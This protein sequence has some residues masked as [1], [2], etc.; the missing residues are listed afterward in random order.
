[1]DKS[2]ISDELSEIIAGRQVQ[3]AVFTSYN[4][5]PDFFEIDVIPYLLKDTIP[6]S[7]DDR[8]K[9]YQVME[10]L[11]DSDIC[12]EVFFDQRMFESSDQSPSMDYRFN[13][14]NLLPYAFHAKNI[15][16]LVKASDT[17]VQ[18]LLMAAGSNNLTRAGWW[19][20]IETQHWV[21]IDNDTAN[22][23]LIGQ[24]R[25]DLEWLKDERN[26]TT[27]DS[28]IEK[29][30]SFLQACQSKEQA[31]P[32][33]YYS[34]R[35]R[36]FF[37]FIE[38]TMSSYSNAG[39][40]RLEIISPF[41]ANDPESLLHE[42]FFTMGVR[43]ILILLPFDQDNRAR[44][45][46]EY[47]ETIRKAD[48]IAWAQWSNNDAKNLGVDKQQE[49]YRKLHAKVF[50]F[51]ND[52][53]S[54]VFSGSVNF[55]RNA[56]YRNVESGFLIR[57][58]RMQPLLQAISDQF[59]VQCADELD[60][61]ELQKVSDHHTHLDIHL[62]YDWKIQKLRGRV[63]HDSLIRVD[64]LDEEG[65]PIIEEWTLGQDEKEYE[66][67]GDTT[68][69]EELLKR[70]SFV[71]VLTRQPGSDIPLAEQTVLVLQTGWSHKPVDL[72]D[73]TPEE[74]LL[75]YAGMSEERRQ[76]LLM[77]GRIKSFLK[78]NLGGELNA[79]D[80]DP[81]Q[82]QFFCEYAEIFQAFRS[83]RNR[84][85]NLLQ[86]HEDKTLDYY[87]SGTGADSLPALI[88]KARD[89]DSNNYNSV[90]A[91]LL[92]LSILEIFSMDNFKSRIKVRKFKAEVKKLI[93]R[94]EKSE[95]IK[96][97][98]GTNR[99]SFFGW[100]REQFSKSY[101]QLDKVV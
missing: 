100:F 34:I 62:G 77:N 72:P 21:S 94:L 28:A 85:G 53:E 59:D 66:D 50:H 96:L 40:W 33:A 51:Y 56:I 12:I 16:L 70:T 36:N 22:Q 31:T 23:V 9:K 95:A 84:L 93:T 37:A 24:L 83:F 8:V 46:L 6:Y 18:S 27:T 30:D 26:L 15:Y 20:N 67:K 76:I 88:E 17:G 80:D 86:R 19:E 13:G 41:F 2:V 35:D 74:I 39:D 99:K 1:M 60:E 73:L 61:T 89:I 82:Q 97:E 71:N 4:F 63:V 87:L 7:N 78:Q 48:R 90:V 10:V 68:R 92:L 52:Q 43:D 45:E 75:I 32:L 14:V 44:C 57:L 42:E 101:E 29:M 55:T 47:Y 3:A 38:N 58:P 54:W 49:Q 81:V 91:Y 64:V 5:E 79:S 69:I 25:N 65:R 11:R 98:A